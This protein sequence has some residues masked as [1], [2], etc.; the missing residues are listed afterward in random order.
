VRDD[1]ERA[2]PGSRPITHELVRDRHRQS[3]QC[4]TRMHAYGGGAWKTRIGTGSRDTPAVTLLARGA[5][6]PV[7]NRSWPPLG[8]AVE[9]EIQSLDLLRDLVSPATCLREPEFRGDAR[10]ARA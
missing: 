2:I 9:V 3:P 10:R 5:H 4:G 7:R 1:Y 8:I 6:L